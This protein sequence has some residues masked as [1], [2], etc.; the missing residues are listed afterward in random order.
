MSEALPSSR[1]LVYAW[2]TEQLDADVDFTD[3]QARIKSREQFLLAHPEL[4]RASVEAAWS[5]VLTRVAKERNIPLTKLKRPAQAPREYDTAEL[6]PNVTRDPVE[7]GPEQLALGGGG[8]RQHGGGEQHGGQQGHQ[9][10]QQGQQQGHGQQQQGQGQGWGQSEQQRYNA[11]AIGAF[12]QGLYVGLQAVIPNLEGLSDGERETLGEIWVDHLN[13]VFAERPR[14]S[15]IMALGGTIGLIGGKVLQARRKSAKERA[16]QETVNK[17]K[18]KAK[19]A[20]Q[21]AQEQEGQ[22]EQPEQVIKPSGAS[23]TTYDDP[24]AHESGGPDAGTQK[25]RPPTR[26]DHE[27]QHQGGREQ[28]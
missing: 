14:L 15:I 13:V 8:G 19:Q 20:A 26:G 5:K 16:E 17:T 6:R 9:G 25:L 12:F 2:I 28:D 24:D 7:I 11:K 10:G 23:Y 18:A 21:G 3:K 22:Q 1:D 27:A 4:K